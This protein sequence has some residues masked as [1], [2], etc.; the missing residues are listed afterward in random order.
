MPVVTSP[1]PAI[2]VTILSGFL[3]A[4]KTTLLQSLLVQAREEEAVRVGV[5]VNEMSPLDVDGRILDTTELLS[6]KD[7]RFA[8]IPAGSI[9]GR[10]GL[11]E[12][13][14]AVAK[15]EGAGVTHI[16]IET[17]GSTHPWPS[18]SCTTSMR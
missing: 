17:S 9:S 2:P 4:G 1:R 7:A 12:F 8:S 5:I 14:A 18:S 15:L 11:A 3:G 10:R 16:I 6:S 13:E